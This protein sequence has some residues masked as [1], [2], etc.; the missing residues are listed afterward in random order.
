M[1]VLFRRFFALIV[2]GITFTSLVAHSANNFSKQQID[3]FKR[4]PLAQQKTL[5][6]QYGI[7]ISML[8]GG[9][10]SIGQNNLVDNS[11]V[12]PRREDDA[13]SDGFD[14]DD[15]FA[16]KTKKLERFGLDLFAGEPITFEPLSNVPVPSDYLIGPGDS[17]KVLLY[18]RSA[19][20]MTLRSTV[21]A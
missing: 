16:P 19:T 11:Y 4:L 9:S 18:G 8:Q 14:F 13:N 1:T 20:N 2:I 17:F 21:K 7:D 6:K 12:P 15:K 3:A 5:A 10:S